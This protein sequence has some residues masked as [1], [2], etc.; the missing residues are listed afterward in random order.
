M[1]KSILAEQQQRLSVKHN[2]DL[3][4]IEDLRTF[5]KTRCHIESNYNQQ[6]AKLSCGH[7]QKKYPQLSVEAQS[8]VK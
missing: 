6:L 4:L 1:A 8:D 7:L 3:D 5:V 2:A